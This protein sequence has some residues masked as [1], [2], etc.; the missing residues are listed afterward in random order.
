MADLGS[1]RPEFLLYA[2]DKMRL[3]GTVPG[4]HRLVAIKAQRLTS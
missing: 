1:L 2:T 3:P 4:P